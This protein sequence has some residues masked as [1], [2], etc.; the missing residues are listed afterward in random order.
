MPVIKTKKDWWDVINVHWR[1][2]LLIF[3]VSVGL[4]NPCPYSPMHIWRTELEELKEDRDVYLA[5]LIEECWDSIDCDQISLPEVQD[6]ILELIEKA[7]ELFKEERF[8]VLKGRGNKNEGLKVNEGLEQK[9]ERF[10]QTVT[11]K[12]PELDSYNSK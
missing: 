6:I 1:E 8:R 10:K 4:D 9:I 11:W 2:V 3:Q 7:D 12:P 5:V